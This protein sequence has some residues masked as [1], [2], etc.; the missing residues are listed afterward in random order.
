MRAGLLS[1]TIRIMRPT[2]TT[3]TVG[4]QV[5]EYAPYKDMFARHVVNRQNRT[6]DNGEIWMPQTFTIEVRIY[7]DIQDYDL[8]QWDGKQYR[9][10]SI[11]TDKTI[12]CKR[13]TI[14]QVNQ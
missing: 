10:L 14:E 3:N 9:I 6:N 8:I 12:R 5:T 13:L 2:V 1:E 7:Q 11:E 4:E